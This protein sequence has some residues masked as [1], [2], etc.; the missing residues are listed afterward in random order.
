MACFDDFDG[1]YF[2]VQA[3]RAYHGADGQDVEIVVVDNHPGSK[4]GQAT[5][6]FCSKA[7]VV[8]HPYEGPP[9]TAGSRQKVF[10]LA[11]A[12]VVCVLD[13]HILPRWGGFVQSVLDAVEVNPR[14]IHQGPLW[15]D[16]LR[17]WHT[18]FKPE[19]REGMW[20]TW[21]TATLHPSG[22]I[23]DLGIIDSKKIATP[24]FGGEPLPADGWEA[25]SLVSVET[26]AP[27]FEIPGQGLGMFACRK[28]VWPGFNPHFRGFGG[29]EMYIH[30]KA[31]Q[32][33]IPTLCQPSLGWIHRFGRPNGVPYPNTWYDR[34]RNYVL[35]HRELG[36]PLDDV[37][38]EFLGHRRVTEETWQSLI[39]NP[40]PYQPP[41]PPA[42]KAQGAHLQWSFPDLPSVLAWPEHKKS[43][44]HIYYSRLQSLSASAVGGVVE[45]SDDPG[46]T[47]YLLS[48]IAEGSESGVT[49]YIH[50]LHFVIDAARRRRGARPHKAYVHGAPDYNGDPLQ[51]EPMSCGALVVTSPVAADGN[52]WRALLDK[53]GPH[54]NGP[55]VLLGG[56]NMGEAGLAGGPGLR[57]TTEAWCDLAGWYCHHHDPQ[58]IGYTEWRRVTDRPAGHSYVRAW[59][60][61]HGVGTELKKLLS[62]VG[63]TATP[64]CGCNYRAQEMDR[65]GPLWCRE[66]SG[67]VIDWLAE[68][69]ARRK[70]GIP[71]TRTGAW[72]VLSLAQKLG[73]RACIKAEGVLK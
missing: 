40:Q 20:G 9:T 6:D 16:N 25:W 47:A 39:D 8:Y 64:T 60:P 73:E 18:H 3:L 45:F 17:S 31:R 4:Q 62:R 69:A 14:A 5:A 56:G 42:P 63:I 59:A 66:N 24:I 37:R 72:A 36:L 51:V 32:L 71:F 33:G 11:S 27:P 54:V 23:V 43:P 12:P 46:T 22:V 15:L 21:Q 19:W 57:V 52:R 2:T 61:G 7:R 35:G 58:G 1:V 67:T 34:C 48:G 50:K 49:S 53:W 44:H 70:D 68:E 30:A 38:S 65:L 13:C 29:E 28:D 41:G 26:W 10:Q 55:I